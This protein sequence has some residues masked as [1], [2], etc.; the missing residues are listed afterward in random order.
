MKSISF[1]V[2]VVG[3]FL[4]WG[5]R[6]HE[7]VKE[8]VLELPVT[9]VIRVDTAI[10]KEYVCVIH[11][12]QHIEVRS[13]DEGYIEQI[14]V[15]EGQW[16]HKGQLMFKILPVIYY[17][18]L[19]RAEA[20]AKAAE[21]EYLN[22]KALADSQIVSRNEL[23][24]AKARYEKAKAELALARARLHFTE[25]RAPFSGLVGR[26]HVRL[27][28]YVDERELLTT[29]SDNRQLWVYFNVPEKEYLEFMRHFK[30]DSVVYVQLRMA[31][32]EL[33]PYKGK[34]TAI[35]AEFNRTTGN[36]AFRATFP[37][38]E[39][40]L[41]HGETG[42]ILL[43]VPMKNVLLIPQKATFE[44]LEHRYVYLVHEDGK[45]EARRIVIGEEF[46]HFYQVVAGLKEG[47]KVL[48]EGLRKVRNGEKIR[49]RLIPPEKVA[50]QL[51]NIYAE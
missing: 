38:P 21:V 2:S 36:V 23:A 11:A 33:F 48:L 8:E 31:S 25:I 16:V 10:Y 29:L 46:P 37:N 12:I 1:Y 3:I 22:T 44:V 35:E 43:R 41:R 24:L 28:S 13:L 34:I 18:E 5:C 49:Y 27:G 45:V 47:D 4:L 32:D 42:N 17:A 6:K 50:E 14:L 40:L 20:E 39:G 19:K 15:D 7:E 30:K 51:R 26:F 9:E